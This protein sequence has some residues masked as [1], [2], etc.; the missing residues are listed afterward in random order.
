[1]TARDAAIAGLDAEIDGITTDAGTAAELFAVVDLL[2]GQPMLRRSLSDPSASDESRAGLARKLLSKRVAPATSLVL[3][4]VVK[5][6]HPS[7]NALVSALDRQGVRL[8]LSQARRERKLD[9]VTAQL[10]QISALVD[11]NHELSST[12]RNPAF[13]VEA[14]RSLVSGLFRGKVSP[15][16][17]ELVNRAVKARRRTFVNTVQGYLDMAARLTGQRI[18]K[19]TVARPLDA[20]RT[21]RLKS[22]LEAQ[23]GGPVSIQITVDPAVLGGVSVSLGDDVYESTVAARLEDARR[24]LINL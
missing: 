15:L 3:E 22:A 20:G 18:A 4:A 16:T 1:M 5:A 10:F 23:I 2:D 12:L 13:P 17:L 19:V 8:A 21:A 6:A 9:E 11:E 14:K 24:Q 7:G